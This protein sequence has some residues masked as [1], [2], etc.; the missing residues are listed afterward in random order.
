VRSLR[1]AAPAN[2]GE[3]AFKVEFF[4]K[5]SLPASLG[6]HRAKT[7]GFD[8]CEHVGHGCAA[9]ESAGCAWL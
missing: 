1:V 9:Q 3:L 7:R 4:E 6:G 2:D 5:R 8:F